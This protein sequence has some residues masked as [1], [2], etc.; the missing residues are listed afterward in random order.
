MGEHMGGHCRPDVG[1]VAQETLLGSA[2][3][4][5]HNAGPMSSLRLISQ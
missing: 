1:A 5:W 4:R 2:R 3:G